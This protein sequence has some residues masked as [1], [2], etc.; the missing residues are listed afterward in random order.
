MAILTL[1][2]VRDL[3]GTNEVAGSKKELKKLCIRIGELAE[4]NGEDWVKENRKKLI[5]EWNFIVKQGI[6]P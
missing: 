1:E 3:L 2:K 5:E 4:L 6:I